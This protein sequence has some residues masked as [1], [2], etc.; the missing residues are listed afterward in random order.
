VKKT[1]YATSLINCAAITNSD[2]EEMELKSGEKEGMVVWM[3]KEVEGR[4]GD[5]GSGLKT[6]T[7]GDGK[8]Y[9]YQRLGKTDLN[10]CTAV[11]M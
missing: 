9:R 8:E 4:S 1:Q 10:S 6:S 3:G 11:K 2:N 5:D 7:M